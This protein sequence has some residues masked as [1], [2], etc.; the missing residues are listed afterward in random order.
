MPYRDRPRGQLFIPLEAR[1]GFLNFLLRQRGAPPLP[2]E[3]DVGAISPPVPSPALPPPGSSPG[4]PPFALPGEVEAA[5]ARRELRELALPEFDCATDLE[6][7]EQARERATIREFNRQ[8]RELRGT[9]EQLKPVEKD[10]ALEKGG[11]AGLQGPLTPEVVTSPVIVKVLE[12][13]LPRILPVTI[14][15]PSP[16][17]PG[18]PTPEEI[19]RMEEAFEP[20]QPVTL[21]D[22]EIPTLP[23]P[24]TSPQRLPTRRPQRAIPTPAPT[25]RPP[26]ER[27][28][29]PVQ[30]PPP[31]EIPPPAP[32]VGPEARPE[33][34][35]RILEIPQSDE[36]P[37][38][39]P[40]RTGS[41]AGQRTRAPSA[42]RPANP[43]GSPFILPIIPSLSPAL[44]LQ[45]EPISRTSTPTQTET[46]S[47]TPTSA[48][49]VSSR[50]GAPARQCQ[51]VTRRRRRKGK[52]RE[53][54]FRELPGKTRFIT[55]REGDCLGAARREIS[56]GIR[57]V[58]RTTGD[59]LGV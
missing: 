37:T 30:R 4:R 50:P 41:P 34:R 25:P 19:R 43:L 26:I 40:S 10:P 28:P 51:E 35:P 2:P 46:A 20:P 18:T 17:A 27:R 6:C 31:V 29:F 39:T 1:F 55:W 14:L 32:E 23:Q 56:G 44:R 54:F 38:Q 5:R 7:F 49:P 21:P 42:A 3:F 11:F 45:L 12:K 13:V 33:I 36:Q 59:V 58:L 24:A 22:V 16:I 15:F 52:C 53:G 47:L 48:A 8:L 9:K 57:E